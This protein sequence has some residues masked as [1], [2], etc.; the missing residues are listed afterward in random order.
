MICPRCQERFFSRNY[1][2][3][4]LHKT[5]TCPQCKWRFPAPLRA[6]TRRIIKEML[7]DDLFEGTWRTLDVPGRVEWL[8]NKVKELVRKE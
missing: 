6:D 4:A 7:P 8:V 2:T 5:V 3:R 1:S